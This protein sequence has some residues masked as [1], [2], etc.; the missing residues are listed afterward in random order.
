MK[1]YFRSSWG[2]NVKD[3]EDEYLEEIEEMLSKLILSMIIQTEEYHK[4]NSFISPN[5]NKK[6]NFYNREGDYRES[7]KQLKEVNKTYDENYKNN[8][9]YQKV[10]NQ[11]E[12]DRRNVK[13]LNKIQ[14]KSTSKMNINYSKKKIYDV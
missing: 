9:W 13:N 3:P 10:K 1:K 11:M 2:Y 6:D 14:T 5:Q 8:Q 7:Y 12:E 4:K